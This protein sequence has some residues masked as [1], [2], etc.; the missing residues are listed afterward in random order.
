[1]ETGQLNFTYDLG[2]LTLY[3]TNLLNFKLDLNDEEVSK[4]LFE[5]SAQN[6]KRIIQSFYAI[7]QKRD[8]EQEA[9]PDE[10]KVIEYEQSQ[11]EIKLPD[12]VTVFPRHKKIP[13]KK[14]LTRWE[15]FAQDKG[16]QN[17]KRGRM[18]WDEIT[19]TWVPRYGKDSIKKIQDKV[20]II[21]EVKQ[22]EDPNEDPFQKKSLEKKLAKEKQEFREV[23]NKLEAKGT[24]IELVLN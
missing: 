19:K 7:K 14:A 24:L 2:N 12:P 4:K 9:V 1:M 17:R 3:D 21:R 15:K 13:E 23:R 18:V 11:Y 22:G 6:I 5:R 20:D 8:E 10:Y 16:I